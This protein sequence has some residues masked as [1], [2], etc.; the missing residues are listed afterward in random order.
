MGNHVI[1]D[2][3]LGVVTSYRDIP[4]ILE[5]KGYIPVELRETWIAMIGFRNILVHDYTDID[6]KLVYDALKNQ[7]DDFQKLRK[8][9]AQFL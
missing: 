8:V 3:N 5:E 4:T 9:F 7:L 2:E 1:A 6:Q